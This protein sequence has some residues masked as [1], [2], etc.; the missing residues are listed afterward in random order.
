MTRLVV[1]ILPSDPV[2]RGMSLLDFVSLVVSVLCFYFGP[3]CR[4]RLSLSASAAL[5]RLDVSFAIYLM[6]SFSH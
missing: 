6:L 5:H 2:S 3:L 1:A 4:S